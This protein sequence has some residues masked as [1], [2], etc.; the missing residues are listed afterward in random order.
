MSNETIWILSNQNERP[1]KPVIDYILQ[2]GADL[3]QATEGKLTGLLVHAGVSWRDVTS[4]L[5]D[6]LGGIT[7]EHYHATLS[8]DATDASY[9][10]KKQTHEFVIV[11][12]THKYELSLFQISCNDTLPASLLIEPTIAEE[13]SLQKHIEIYNLE[14]FKKVF[15]NIIHCRKVIYIINRLIK[16]PPPLQAETAENENSVTDEG[17]K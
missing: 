6:A 5:V 3:A 11:D 17:A 9:L 8:K 14:E 10:Y 13:A 16:L 1:S 12:E 4:T 15:E 2:Q 7:N